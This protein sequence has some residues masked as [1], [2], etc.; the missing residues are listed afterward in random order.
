MINILKDIL[1]F[2][3]SIDFH[4]FIN[5]WYIFFGISFENICTARFFA[6][7]LQPQTRKRHDSMDVKILVE[8]EIRMRIEQ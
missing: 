2:I 4:V 1:T 5:R 8:T 3:D 7:T 6:I